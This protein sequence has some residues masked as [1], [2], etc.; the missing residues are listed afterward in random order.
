M[1]RELPPEPNTTD[2]NILRQWMTKERDRLLQ[3]ILSM[4]RFILLYHG[5]Y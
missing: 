5:M 2:E 3:E 4:V 1:G